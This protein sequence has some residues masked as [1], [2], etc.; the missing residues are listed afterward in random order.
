MACLIQRLI[1]LKK[2]RTLVV[3]C[4]KFKSRVGIYTGDLYQI[5]ALCVK[6]ENIWLLF[7]V[8]SVL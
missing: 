8:V 1:C 7:G 5:G 3:G 2:K 4:E 6:V